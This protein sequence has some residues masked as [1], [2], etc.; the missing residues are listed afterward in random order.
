M[1]A[2]RK[3]VHISR[4][5]PPPAPIP[6]AHEDVDD[7]PLTEAELAAIAADDGTYIAWEVIKAELGL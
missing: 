2:A 5:V 4:P 7:E 1:T 3:H 6:D